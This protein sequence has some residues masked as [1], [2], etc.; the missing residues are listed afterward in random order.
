MRLQR[1]SHVANRDILVIQLRFRLSIDHII[2]AERYPGS[3]PGLPPKV[4][5]A[6]NGSITQDAVRALLVKVYLYE[7][8]WTF[9]PNC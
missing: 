4:S 3:I 6:E 7:Q 5:A 9:Y 1:E 8:K 2:V